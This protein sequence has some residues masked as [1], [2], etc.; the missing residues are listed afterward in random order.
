MMRGMRGQVLV[1]FALAAIGVGVL[2]ALSGWVV[3]YLTG[4][5]VS[6]NASYQITRKQAGT[7]DSGLVGFGQGTQRGAGPSATTQ[8][9]GEGEQ[10]LTEA[11]QERAVIASLHQLGQQ[12]SQRA[13]EKANQAASMIDQ[14]N[15]LW[16]QAAAMRCRSAA[17]A[18]AQAE[19]F[20]QANEKN[21]QAHQLAEQDQPTLTDLGQ[22][23]ESMALQI[24]GH[25]FSAEEKERQALVACA[26]KE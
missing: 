17:C 1:E 18:R 22:R 8:R 24:A 15:A 11:Q 12:A 26:R 21:N 13:M 6:R 19:L 20:R 25:L 7:P 9:C 16:D 2:A 23:S 5:L 14:A 3:N 10:L 4:S